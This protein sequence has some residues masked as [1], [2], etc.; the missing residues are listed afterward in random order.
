VLNALDLGHKSTKVNKYFSS[1]PDVPLGQE[2]L[3]VASVLLV[4]TFII[5]VSLFT[6]Y[7]CFVLIVDCPFGMTLPDAKCTYNEQPDPS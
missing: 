3:R 4:N 1:F 2:I 7:I 5:I 6:L